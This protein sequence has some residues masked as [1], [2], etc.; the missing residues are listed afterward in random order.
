MEREAIDRSGETKW[1][2]SVATPDESVVDSPFRIVSTGYSMLDLNSPVEH[3]LA[4]KESVTPQS[5]DT[6]GRRIF[7]RYKRKPEVRVNGF[8]KSPLTSSVTQKSQPVNAA[9]PESGAS[10]SSD[11]DDDDDDAGRADGVDRESHDPLHISPRNAAG[12]KLR[13]E[14]RAK[15]KS[16][17]AEL[18]RMAEERR[19]KRVNLNELT[20]ISSAGSN[21]GNAA[22]TCYK[23][24]EKGHPK[25]RC[26]KMQKRQR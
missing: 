21:S 25:A 6:P 10:G 23:C 26:P 18:A 7:G 16:D 9:A 5:L 17:K 20:S 13:T 1:Y 11:D 22:M 8:V 14:R 24:G 12:E 19:N 3:Q 4:S 15:A 2:M